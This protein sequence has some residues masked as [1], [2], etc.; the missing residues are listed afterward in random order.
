MKEYAKEHPQ[1]ESKLNNTQNR[2]EISVNT[3]I[4]KRKSGSKKKVKLIPTIIICINKT[5]TNTMLTITDGKGNVLKRFSAG[6]MSHPGTVTKLQGS[7][8]KTRYASELVMKAAVAYLKTL[9]K[10]KNTYAITITG[11]NAHIGMKIA[12]FN[13]HFANYLRYKLRH[14]I[15]QASIRPKHPYNGCRLPKAKRK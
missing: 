13:R 14:P 6:M 11:K 3:R 9:K 12:K 2:T 5:Y 8:R 7:K 1:V 4:N 15:A 10:K